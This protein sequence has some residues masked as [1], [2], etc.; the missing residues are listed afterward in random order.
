VAGAFGLDIYI[1]SLLDAQLT[2]TQL[3]QLLAG[4]PNRCVLLFE[5]IDSA[6]LVRDEARHKTDCKISL[7]CLLNAIDGVSSP[8]GR[9]LIMTT[10]HPELLDPALVRPGR[11]DLHIGFVLPGH[12]ELE[13]LFLSMYSKAV[14]ISELISTEKEIS[15][16]STC[17]NGI[18][19][20]NSIET[21]AKQFA[22]A[23]PSSRHS[24]ASAQ[25]YLLQHKRDP[26]AAVA[27]AKAWSDKELL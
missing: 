6:G 7:S 8:D 21:L 27:G 5:D 15:A 4:L 12:A 25:G 16:E 19:S 26:I 10:N 14:T 18:T 13:A 23:L 24:L 1:L 17:I 22:E 3:M 20:E 11:V 2:E 9:L